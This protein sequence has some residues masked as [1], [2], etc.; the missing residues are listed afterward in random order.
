MYRVYKSLVTKWNPNRSPSNKVEDEAKFQEINEPFK[1]INENKAKE[2]SKSCNEP[3]V[4]SPGEASHHKSM[5]E[6]LFYRPAILLKSLSR[7]S[8]TQST[9]PTFLPKSASSR[10][11]SSKNESHRGSFDIEKLVLQTSLSRLSP[12][13]PI[14]FSQSTHLRKP[15]PIEKKLEC[16]LEELCYGCVKQIMISRDVIINGIIEQQGEM[17]SITV[18]PGWKRGTKITFDG[19][20]D[21]RPGYQPADL[22]LVIDEKPHLLFEREDD[23][24]VYKAEIPLLEALVGYN[25]SVPLLEG[26]KMSLSFDIIFPG[27]VK[28]IKGQGMPSAKEIGKRG[29]LRIIFLIN[30]PLFL[31][32]E[33]RFNA[34]TILKDCSYPDFL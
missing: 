23:N 11:N 19:K 28:I 14:I 17:V 2:K 25:L 30:F 31:S 27:Y 26:E 4:S 21:E 9:S 8:S 22:I 29:D 18:K 16:T 32:S 13:S 3:I 34:S 5:E 15:P 33:Q 10:D 1:V 20:G 7:K 12:R 24:L 6:S